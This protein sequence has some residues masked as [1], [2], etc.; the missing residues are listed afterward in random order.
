MIEHNLQSYLVKRIKEHTVLL[1][2]IIGLHSLDPPV[3]DY[4][5]NIIKSTICLLEE[6]EDLLR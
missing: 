1:E 2:S 4:D 6:I 5:I 3:E